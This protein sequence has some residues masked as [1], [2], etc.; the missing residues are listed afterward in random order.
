MSRWSLPPLIP[1]PAIARPLYSSWHRHCYVYFETH[2]QLS[3]TK[4]RAIIVTNF[5]LLELFRIS[6]TVRFS[7]PFVERT[8]GLNA[9]DC[10]RHRFPLRLALVLLPR[11]TSE[12]PVSPSG[13]PS[14]FELC[15]TYNMLT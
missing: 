14:R 2:F 7:G 6:L 12:L 5:A 8:P 11:F 4:H 1:T 13:P 10:R 3:Q 9:P 15:S